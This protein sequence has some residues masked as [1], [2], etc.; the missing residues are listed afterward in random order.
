VGTG[1]H[2]HQ[3]HDRR[4]QQVV[5]PGGHAQVAQPRAIVRLGERAALPWTDLQ[6][7]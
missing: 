1:A 3:H 6:R 2:D 4:I 5:D 7:Q